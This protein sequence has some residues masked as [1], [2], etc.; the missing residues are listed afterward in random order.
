[1]RADAALVH[2]QSSGRSSHWHRR[3]RWPWS[4]LHRRT[5][6]AVRRLA[7]AAVLLGLASTAAGCGGGSSTA[8][9]TEAQPP[10]QTSAPP[11]T[12]TPSPPSP[13]MS[14]DEAGAFVWHESDV[15]PEV[16]GQ[17]LRDNGF[18]WVAVFLHDGLTADPVED[19]W[20]ARFRRRAGSSSAAGVPCVPTRSRKPGSRAPSSR[21]TGST[22]TS[23]TLRPSTGT[24]G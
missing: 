8:T 20:I 11:P 12:A 15:S 4:A 17:E 21:A 14:W 19:D 18:G 5:V 10:I 9:P 2:G 24:A 3:S 23:P 1:V 13:P 7:L 22:S 16:L 6:E